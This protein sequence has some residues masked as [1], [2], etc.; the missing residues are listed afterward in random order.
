MVVEGRGPIGEGDP[1]DYIDRPAER[2]QRQQH[3][4]RLWQWQLASD[5]GLGADVWV[6]QSLQ[7]VRGRN[8]Q[9]GDPVERREWWKRFESLQVWG[10]C[11]RG[12]PGWDWDGD[13]DWDCGFLL[14]LST[15]HLHPKDGTTGTQVATND[16]V[17][18]S[19]AFSP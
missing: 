11:V 13:W 15:S 18:R 14:S 16:T 8:W 6:C 2:E 3:Q 17:T 10:G 4:N 5:K 12:L 7:V 1:S 19:F 9:G